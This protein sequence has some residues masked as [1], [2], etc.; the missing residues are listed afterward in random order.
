MPLNSCKC[1]NYQKIKWQ[2]RLGSIKSRLSTFDNIIIIIIFCIFRLIKVASKF[3]LMYYWI[4]RIAI[5][6]VCLT[7]ALILDVTLDCP[8]FCLKA[9]MWSDYCVQFFIALHI[10]FPWNNVYGCRLVLS[11]KAERLHKNTHTYQIHTHSIIWN[12]NKSQKKQTNAGREEQRKMCY[13]AQV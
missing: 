4:L 11:Q 6:G 3:T 1:K 5:I 10:D 9:E 7:V 2:N 13:R 8:V 12:S